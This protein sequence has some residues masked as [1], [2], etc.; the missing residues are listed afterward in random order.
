MFKP[1]RD[2][3][4]ELFT[5]VI[6]FPP[7][8]TGLGNAHYHPAFIVADKKSQPSTPAPPDP[9]IAEALLI[10]QRQQSKV[11][12]ANT[13]LVRDPQGNE[14][15]LNANAKVDEIGGRRFG[16]SVRMNDDNINQW[17]TPEMV[18]KT[19]LPGAKKVL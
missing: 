13:M 10:D 6:R 1:T 8:K 5:M 19:N 2:L 7:N 14:L 15:Y 18:V 16:T 11:P 12:H 3:G 17:L 9:S 4:L